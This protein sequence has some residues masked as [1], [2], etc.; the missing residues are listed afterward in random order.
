MLSSFT[1]IN[2]YVCLLKQI[3]EYHRVIKKPIA[4]D[5]I[6]EKLKPESEN[7]YTDLKQVIADIRLMFKNAYTFN[8]VSIKIFKL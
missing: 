1:F 3:A 8:S 6:K 4:L 7:H 5:V 2:I